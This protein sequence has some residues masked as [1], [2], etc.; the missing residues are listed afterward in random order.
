MRPYLLAF[1]TSLALGLPLAAAAESP[2]LTVYSGDY[3]AVAQ[4]GGPPGRIGLA[5]YEAELR[6]ELPAG[7]SEQRLGGLPAALDAGSVLLRPRGQARVAGQR[8]DFAIAGQEEL[9]RR[10]IGRQVTVEQDIGG[11]RQTHTGVLLAAGNG[12]SLRLPDGRVRVLS[13]YASF[14]L[15][16]LPEGVV[17]E[18][19]LVWTLDATRAGHQAFDLA[20]DTGGLGWRAEYQAELAGQGQACRMRLEGGAMVV[21]RSGTDF[22]EVALTLVAG[23]PNRASA[24][25]VAEMAAVVVSGTRAKATYDAAPDARVAGESHAYRIPGLSTLADGSIQRLPLLDAAE[26]IVCERRY[27]IGT[28]GNDWSPPQPILDRNFNGDGGERPV[29]ANLAFRNRGQG[30]GVPLPA[31]RVRVSEN[32]DLLGEAM[33]G[34][35]AAGAEVRLSLGTAFDLDAE[36]TRAGFQLDRAGRQMTETV[37]YTV[38]NAKAGAATVRIHEPMPRWS[39]WELVS[40]SVPAAAR[41][42][43]SASF[44]LKVPAGGE[45]QLE[46]TV[47][48]RWAPD[49]PTR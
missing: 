41:D 12:L 14:E 8:F 34:H 33:I 11:S 43:Q 45:A 6:F 21:N 32:G 17:N 29:T 24:P 20:Y 37:R 48:Y 10:A 26:G 13:E 23:E 38:R 7:R 22:R 47:R 2:R 25:V 49:V 19:T 9:L 35:T 46:Y 28:P 5:R 1:A 31:G 3:E 4:S 42:A 15:P 16:A 27:D 39:E 44:D 30:L 18:P 36:R 40:S